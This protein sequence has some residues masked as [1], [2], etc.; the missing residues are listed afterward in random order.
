MGPVRSASAEASG[1]RGNRRVPPD[2]HI[3]RVVSWL[4]S[5]LFLFLRFKTSTS[6]PRAAFTL[7]ELH[8]LVVQK[9]VESLG[10]R[11]VPS[12]RPVAFL[13]LVGRSHQIR[14][15][16]CRTGVLRSVVERVGTNGR[17]I[18]SRREELG[19]CRRSFGKSGVERSDRGV[20]GRSMIYY[21]Q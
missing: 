15:P 10:R 5:S 13:D 16:R 11:A 20:V 17:R 19:G 2:C 21:V 12:V 1:S 6:L 8:T 14:E 3:C 9:N 18:W 4:L 7:P